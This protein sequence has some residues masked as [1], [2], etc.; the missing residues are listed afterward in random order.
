MNSTALSVRPFDPDAARTN[1]FR[2]QFRNGIATSSSWIEDDTGILSKL[3]C[4]VF[5]AAI[6]AVVGLIALAV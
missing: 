2:W 4:A 3:L 6:A 5:C 1:Q